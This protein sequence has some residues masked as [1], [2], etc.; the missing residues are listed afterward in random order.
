MGRIL[1]PAGSKLAGTS[2][3]IDRRATPV[4]CT[5][6]RLIIAWTPATRLSGQFTAALPTRE[7]SIGRGPLLLAARE[8]RNGGRGEVPR[9]A[10]SRTAG[11]RQC[12]RS[13]TWAPYG[14]SWTRS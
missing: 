7:G 9:A 8:L 14:G 5:R 13:M 6:L 3:V 12:Y 1:V 11:R 4:S 10:S 2:A